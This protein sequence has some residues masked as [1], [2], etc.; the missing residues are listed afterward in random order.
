MLLS[1]FCLCSLFVCLVDCH[2][3]FL[4]LPVC[5]HC[6]IPL[7]LYIF[8]VFFFHSFVFLSDPLACS[9]LLPLFSKVFISP[10]FLSVSSPSFHTLHTL[11]RGNTDKRQC[12]EGYNMHSASRTLPVWESS[13]PLPP[14]SP[15]SQ[16]PSSF[17]FAPRVCS[18]QRY[19]QRKYA[20]VNVWSMHCKDGVPL[21]ILNVVLWRFQRGCWFPACD[22]AVLMSS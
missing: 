17:S 10:I 7:F 16:S 8:S 11:W 14:A 12:S 21:F 18:G 15:R 1:V 19:T 22:V 13:S 6:S 5:I 9:L 3:F 20:N 4:L 2:Y